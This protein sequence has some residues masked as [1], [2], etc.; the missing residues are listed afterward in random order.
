MHCFLTET[1]PTPIGEMVL[2]ARDGVL[3]LLE[4]ADAEGRVEREMRWRFGDVELQPASN[5]NTNRHNTR[6]RAVLILL[7]SLIWMDEVWYGAGSNEQGT[8][9]AM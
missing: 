7:F 8:S 6:A 3:L 1:I 2:V 5:P 4:F 9:C